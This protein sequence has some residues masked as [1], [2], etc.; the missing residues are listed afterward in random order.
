MNILLAV[1]NS[2]FSEAAADAI[3]SQV[4]PDDAH[5]RLLHVL[6]PFP[7][8]LAKELGDK[9]Q[10]DFALARVKLREQAKE[11]LAL[12]AEKLRYAG[13]EVSISV[14]DGDARDVI[15]EWADRWPADLIVVGSHGSSGIRRFLLGSVSDAII[16][17][18]H[19][20]VEVVRIKEQKAAR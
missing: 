15:L 17:H 11:Y 20:S 4:K 3:I 1:E 18:A 19:C 16:R 7:M 13:F 10:P 9:D 6:E 8:A 2:N 12:I 14:E 5:I